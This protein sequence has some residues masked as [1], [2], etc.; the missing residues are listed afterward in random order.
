MGREVHLL[1][2]LMTLSALLAAN[3][4][5]AADYTAQRAVDLAARGKAVLVD[6]RRSSE[7]PALDEIAGGPLIRIVWPAGDIVDA[8][9]TVSNRH[10]AFYRRLK[11]EW[12]SNPDKLVIL[13]CGVGKRSGDAL[14]MAGQFGM[15][16]R[17]GHVTGGYQGNA[18]DPGLAA[19]MDMR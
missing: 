6:L 15:H 10:A 2:L 14:T 19:E 11:S 8:H 17:L 3:A 12:Q 16:S 1:R 7:Q 9:G 5:C 18:A 13:F 4:A